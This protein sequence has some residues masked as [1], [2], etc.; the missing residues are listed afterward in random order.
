MDADGV[1]MDEE[2]MLTTPSINLENI[3]RRKTACSLR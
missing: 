1:Y 2:D 3:M